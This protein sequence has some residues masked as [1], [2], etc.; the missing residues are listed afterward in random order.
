MMDILLLK[1]YFGY[2]L[3]ITTKQFQSIL[4]EC[5]KSYI[6]FYKMRFYLDATSG[7]EITYESSLNIITQHTYDV[8]DF[9][10]MNSCV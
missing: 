7:P 5:I 1:Q 9:V 2:N 10:C 6:A 4:L 3:K 8:V